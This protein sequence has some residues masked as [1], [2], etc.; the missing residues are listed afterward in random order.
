MLRETQPSCID[1]IPG[2]SIV[3]TFLRLLQVFPRLPHQQQ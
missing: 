1:V 2:R 3:Q